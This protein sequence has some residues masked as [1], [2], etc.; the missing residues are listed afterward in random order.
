MLAQACNALSALCKPFNPPMC[1]SDLVAGSDG[2]GIG[3]D[4]TCRNAAASLT[5]GGARLL[6]VDCGGGDV[7]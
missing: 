1:A 6:G 5:V 2:D 4:C 3:G 7:G